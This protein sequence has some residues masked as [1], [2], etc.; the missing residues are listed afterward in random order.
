MSVLPHIRR[1]RELL[2]SC[3]AGQGLGMADVLRLEQ[4]AALLRSQEEASAGPTISALLTRGSEEHAVQL[5]RLGPEQVTCEGCPRILPGT[6]LGLRLDECS[7][8]ASYLFR[9]AVTE[10]HYSLETKRWTLTLALIGCPVVLNWTRG[11]APSS[12]AVLRLEED[13]KKAA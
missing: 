1:Y 6:T 2:Q 11:R 10:S 7:D 8:D 4:L 13:M 12:E 3:D 5:T 9:A